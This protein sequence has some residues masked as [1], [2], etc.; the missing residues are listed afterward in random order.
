M[1]SSYSKNNLLEQSHLIIATVKTTTYTSKMWWVLF[2]L[3]INQVEDNTT[4]I[5]SP[6]RKMDLR[7]YERNLQ[8]HLVAVPTK[9]PFHRR[10]ITVKLLLDV[11]LP[12]IIPDTLV[13]VTI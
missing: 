4:N 5:H 7:G 9:N 12:P 2:D 8:D 13:Q 1:S 11:L 6:E 3:C 10:I